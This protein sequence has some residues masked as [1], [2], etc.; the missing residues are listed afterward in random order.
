MKGLP[1]AAMLLVSA[2]AAD[3]YA[4]TRHDRMGYIYPDRCAAM[5][6]AEVRSVVDPL[7]VYLPRE[8]LPFGDMAQTMSKN[9][10]SVVMIRAGMGPE[11]T[12]DAKRHEACHVV[13][14]QETGQGQW[15]D[16]PMARR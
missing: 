10:F 14:Y 5:T 7:A 6:D 8:N 16:Q 15:H 3:P 12:A 13:M 4:T 9:G 1:I 2:C 11:E